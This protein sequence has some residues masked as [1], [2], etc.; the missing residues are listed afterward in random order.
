MDAIKALEIVRDSLLNQLSAA[1]EAKLM[2]EA[3][4][5]LLFQNRMMVENLLDKAKAD[6]RDQ[7]KKEG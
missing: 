3:Q 7:T 4:I 6:A 2:A 1:R 5:E